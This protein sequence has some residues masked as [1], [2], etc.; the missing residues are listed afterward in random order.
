MNVK[1]FEV[2]PRDGLQNESEILTTEQKFQFI[3]LLMDAGHKNIEVGAFVRPDKIP[4]MADSIQLLKRLPLKKGFFWSLVPNEKGFE[5]ATSVGIKNIA[6]FTAASETFN[7]KN[8]NTSIDGSFE[9]FQSFVP[10]AK[11][12]GYKVRGYISTAFGCP[13]EG[14]VNPKAVLKVSERLLKLKCD[15]VS[16]GDTIG[17]A[18]PL[19]TK[20]LVKDL[21][22]V[23]GAKKLAL[24]FHDTRGLALANI[25]AALECGVRIFDSSSGGLGGCPFAPGA[26]GNVATDDLLYMLDG[27]GVKTGINLSRNIKASEFI[28]RALG[29]KLPS[30]YLQA[31][32]ANQT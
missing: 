19:Q 24:H 22:R 4:Q 31:A 1:I 3:K 28:Q 9:R 30:K 2:G 5:I 15:E 18:N 23:V 6:I 26:T 27:M 14:K 12:N 16:V 10:R 25:L 21:L 8:I 32:L 11:K 17:V 20:K 7:Q 13:F 29:R